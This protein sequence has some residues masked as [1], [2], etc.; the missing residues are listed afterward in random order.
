MKVFGGSSSSSAAA[1]EA[2][3]REAEA[4]KLRAEADAAA[5]RAAAVAAA[6]TK[7]SGGLG[8]LFASGNLV[9]VFIGAFET[10]VS[11]TKTGGSTEVR[12]S[13][14]QKLGSSDDR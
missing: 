1:A 3:A 6:N 7:P 5:A 2:R 12:I 14:S 8:D 13:D 9:D 4:A 10:I 11:N